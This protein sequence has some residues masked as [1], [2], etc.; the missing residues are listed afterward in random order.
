MT[1]A[2]LNAHWDRLLSLSKDRFGQAMKVEG[3][4]LMI[5]L[6]EVQQTELFDRSIPKER[7]MDLMHV[8][9]C[10]VLEPA[11]YYVRQPQ[12]AD[13]W[14]HWDLVQPLP[15]MDILQQG[16]LLRYALVRYFG[17]WIAASYQES[18]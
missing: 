2:E 3:L 16:R 11:G 15:H 4:L 17:E 12:D 10:A 1:D 7:K 8:G 13:G 6:Q 5:G 18:L 9:M 14:P